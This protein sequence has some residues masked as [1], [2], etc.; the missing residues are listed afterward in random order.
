MTVLDTLLDDFPTGWRVKDV[1][2]GENWIASLAVNGQGV[3]QAGVAMAP[4]PIAAEARFQ[5]GHCQP[6]EPAEGLGRRLLS[7]DM[8]EAAVALA[9]LN[10]LNQPPE[11]RLTIAHAANWLSAQGAGRTLAIF[12]RFPFI[13]AELRPAARQVWVFEQQPGP[14]EYDGSNVPLLVPQADI[15]AITGSSVIN[16]TIDTILPYVRPGSTVV[17]LGPST[18]LC[19]KLFAIGIDAMFGV[20]VA[21]VQQVVESVVGGAGFQKMQGLQRVALLKPRLS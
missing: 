9:T 16:H 20:R 3:I 17:L 13:D 14:G 11:N 1:Y 5:I 10:A 7:Q 19:E 6:D 2:V 15:V 18:P 8:T 12:G 21:N 4:H